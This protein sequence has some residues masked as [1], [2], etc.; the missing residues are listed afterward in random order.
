MKDQLLISLSP[1]K[2]F[3]MTVRVPVFSLG[4]VLCSLATSAQ[5]PDV[6]VAASVVEPHKAEMPMENV[7]VHFLEQ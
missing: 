6:S 1:V 7:V 3:A 5:G 2:A 4:L